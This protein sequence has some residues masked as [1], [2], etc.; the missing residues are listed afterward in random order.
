MKCLNGDDVYPHGEANAN[1]LLAEFMPRA[2][3]PDAT[4]GSSAESQ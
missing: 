2:A 4:R 1:A 3:A